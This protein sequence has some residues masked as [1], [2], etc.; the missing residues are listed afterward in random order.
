VLV[1]ANQHGQWCA[2]KAPVW[3]S[4]AFVPLQTRLVA[5]GGYTMETAYVRINQQIQFYNN[6]FVVP[7]N[8]DGATYRYFDIRVGNFVADVGG[9]ADSYVAWFAAQQGRTV[10]PPLK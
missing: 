5:G 7:G 2:W 6:D 10:I 1:R 3:Q 9:A 4:A 8:F